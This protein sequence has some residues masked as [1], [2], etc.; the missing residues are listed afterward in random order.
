MKH[1]WKGI[2][3]L[4]ISWGV[5]LGLSPFLVMG[6]SNPTSVISDV[7]VAEIDA[8]TN[9]ID[10]I[11]DDLDREGFNIVYLTAENR[12]GYTIAVTINVLEYSDFKES[13]KQD[14]MEIALEGILNSN[15]SRTNRNKLYN[16]IADTD[17]ATA[18]LLRNLGSDVRVDLGQAYNMIRP[19]SGW[20]GTLLAALAI[21]LMLFLG[22]TLI[23]DTAWLTIPILQSIL[24]GD[25]DK[26][27][28]FISAE[29]FKSLKAAYDGSSY[30][31]PLLIYIRSKVGHVI[32]VSLC[33]LYLS[34]GLLFSALG[35]LIDKFSGFFK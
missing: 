4:L 31:N 32:A 6:A 7:S 5:V 22:V 17:S 8:I 15:I 25:G 12:G 26:K 14:I 21:G 18:N 19:M 1:L 24:P 23:I 16:F 28:K 11:N 33:V 10:S 13:S 29:A 20:L 34:S 9:A 30:K 3:A 2:V 35:S 27:P